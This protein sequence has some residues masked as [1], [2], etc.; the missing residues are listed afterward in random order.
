MPKIIWL[1]GTKIY[2]DKKRIPN[3]TIG[4]HTMSWNE[5]LEAWEYVA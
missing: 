5:N 4:I 1:A 3:H 2:L